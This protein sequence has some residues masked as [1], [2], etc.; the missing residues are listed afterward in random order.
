[1]IHIYIYTYNT[2]TYYI[3]QMYTCHIPIKLN[4]GISR[5]FSTGRW[6]VEVFVH[7]KYCVGGQPAVGDE[8]TFDIESF[9]WMAEDPSETT[10]NYMGSCQAY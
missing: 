5:W 10:L 9:G 4:T 1:M 2:Y 7:V 8:V 6:N 3:E